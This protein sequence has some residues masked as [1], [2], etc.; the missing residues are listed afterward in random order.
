[1]KKCLHQIFRT[2]I[3]LPPEMRGGRGDCSTCT[4][5]EANKN[6]VG[7]YPIALS[8]IEIKEVANELEREEI[9]Q[10]VVFAATV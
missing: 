9:S 4:T 3:H 7:F 8:I 6:C 5:D 2:K 1:M 10:G